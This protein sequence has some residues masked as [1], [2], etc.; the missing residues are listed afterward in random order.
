MLGHL[1]DSY[2]KICL[3]PMM[4]LFTVISKHIHDL[5]C[6]VY[7]ILKMSL[8]YQYSNELEFLDFKKTMM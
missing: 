3:Q 7:F 5:E 2:H 6:V 1:E 8:T 4:D